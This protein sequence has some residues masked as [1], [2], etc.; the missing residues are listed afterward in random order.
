M[1]RGTLRTAGGNRLV[2]SA[3]ALHDA[4]YNPSRSDNEAASAA[5]WRRLAGQSRR[6][7]RALIR[8][9]AA[10]IEATG[11]HPDAAAGGACEPWVQWVLD[12]DLTPLASSRH[13]FVANRSRL[14]SEQSHLSATAWQANTRRFYAALQRRDRIF[15]FPCMATAFEANARRHL[16]HALHDRNG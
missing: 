7:P 9:V 11:R 4:V 1:A 2:A 14:R 13:R 12:L 5:L 8:Q 15:H 16:R 6:L 3:I 10:A